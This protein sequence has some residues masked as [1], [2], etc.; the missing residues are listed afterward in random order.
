MQRL[1]KFY[2]EKVFPEWAAEL[3]NAAPNKN[4]SE[5]G[6]KQNGMLSQSSAKQKIRNLSVGAHHLNGGAVVGDRES[7]H[8]LV[9]VSGVSGAPLVEVWHPRSGW[10]DEACATCQ[11]GFCWRFLV[12]DAVG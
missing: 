12:R 10:R 8:D 1:K 5:S 2:L 7:F 4:V 6:S 11:T 3:K 9:L